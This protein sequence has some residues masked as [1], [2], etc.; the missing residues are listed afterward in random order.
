MQKKEIL[1]QIEKLVKV[2]EDKKR[3]LLEKLE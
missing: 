3:R 2:I 1:S